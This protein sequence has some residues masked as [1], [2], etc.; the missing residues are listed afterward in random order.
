MRRVMA[1]TKF[2]ATN[3]QIPSKEFGA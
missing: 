2:V 1:G 3:L